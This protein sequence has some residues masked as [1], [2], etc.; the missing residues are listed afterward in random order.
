M[1]INTRTHSIRLAPADDEAAAPAYNKT[2]KRRTGKHYKHTET[3]MDTYIHLPTSTYI[4]VNITTLG[5]P[6][7]TTRQLRQRPVI[8]NRKA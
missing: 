2:E 4:H 8:Q 6:Q 7:Q 3:H 1:Y 5:W